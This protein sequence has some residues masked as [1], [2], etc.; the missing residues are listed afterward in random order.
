MIRLAYLSTS[1]VPPATIE[2]ELVG[3]LETSK[4]NNA[5]LGITG[6]L[7]Y[8]AGMFMQILEGPEHQVFH[9]YVDILDDKRHTEC[10]VILITTIEKRA[11]P[12]WSMAA[13]EGSKPDF[14]RI[15]EFM[16]RR[17]ETHDAKAFACLIDRFVKDVNQN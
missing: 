9:K 10:R 2:K 8:G 4:S 15:Q 16:S 12:N 17:E 7:V 13:F 6:V 1:L 3:I 11:F 14:S 5:V